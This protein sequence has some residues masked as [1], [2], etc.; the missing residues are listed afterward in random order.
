MVMI[1]GEIKLLIYLY[2]KGLSEFWYAHKM[3]WIL[4]LCVDIAQL[5]TLIFRSKENKI[6][7]VSFFIIFSLFN[8]VLLILMLKTKVRTIEKLRPG[9]FNFDEVY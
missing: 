8:T 5:F 4:N 2:R 7:N 9:I 1:I 3:L 6:L